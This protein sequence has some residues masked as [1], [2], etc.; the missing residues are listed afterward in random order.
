MTPSQQERVFEKNYAPELLRIAVGDYKSALALSRA[1][2]IRVENVFYLCQQAIEKSIKAVLVHLGL[3]VPLVHDLGSILSR[4]P[5]D[6]QSPH[7]YELLELNQYASIRRYE[8]GVW[9]P[10]AEEMSSV[11]QMTEEMIDW[12]KGVIK[13]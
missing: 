10:T 1:T 4:L 8:E 12:A 9:T 13:T 11:L 7:G 2:D 5:P 3:A 6:K